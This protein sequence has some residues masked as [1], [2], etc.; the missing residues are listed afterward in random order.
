M[1]LSSTSSTVDATVKSSKEEKKYE[2]ESEWEKELSS[3]HSATTWIRKQTHFSYDSSHMC[4]CVCVC[5]SVRLSARAVVHKRRNALG[6]GNLNSTMSRFPYCF[7]LRKIVQC[8]G[9]FILH[10]KIYTT[11]VSI[12]AFLT[13][14]ENM[15]QKYSLYFFVTLNY[16]ACTLHLKIP[17][18]E[19]MYKNE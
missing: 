3:T 9:P 6:L 19:K 5:V 7:L 4:V 15:K 16:F 18:T 10:C 11:L 13:W 12:S 14:T 1:C 8:L 2:T 17:E